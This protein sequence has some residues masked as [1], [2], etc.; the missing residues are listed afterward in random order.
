MN[1]IKREEHHTLM[2][3]EKTYGGI[4]L[5]IYPKA[6]PLLSES[7]II[8]LNRKE[9]RKLVNSLKAQLKRKYK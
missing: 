5:R 6:M 3:V 1:T 8:S 9:A 7:R 4:D 2:T